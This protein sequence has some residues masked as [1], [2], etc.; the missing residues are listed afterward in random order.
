M[1]W[2]VWD[3][4]FGVLVRQTVRVVLVYWVNVS[5]GFGAGSHGLSSTVVVVVL[6]WAT[7][8]DYVCVR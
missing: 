5:E 4:R 7:V 8:C 2:E 3:G 1:Y 6:F